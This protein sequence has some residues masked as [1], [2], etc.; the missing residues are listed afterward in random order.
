[1][2]I[3]KQE[4]TLRFCVSVVI[5]TAIGVLQPKFQTYQLVYELS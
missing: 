3:I 4:C 1:M 5:S 2:Q